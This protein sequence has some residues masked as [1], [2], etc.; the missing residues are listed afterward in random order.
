MLLP[1]LRWLLAVLL[2]CAALAA[3]A[4]AWA[5][6]DGSVPFVVSPEEVVDRMLRIAQLRPDDY[7][8]D[9]G[10][11]DGRIVIEA[12]RRGAR[13]LGVD[14]DPSLVARARESAARE[15]LAERA[16]FEVRD[17]FDTDLSRATVITLYLLPEFNLKLMPRLLALKPGTRVVS[18]DWDMGSWEPD[19]TIELRV[20][21]K[22]LGLEPR[23]KVYL[24]VIPADVRGNWVAEI[25]GYARDWQFR[26]GQTVQR[27]EVTARIDGREMLVRGTRLRG[28]E[29]RLALTGLVGGHAAHH[30]FKGTVTGDRIAGEV[31]ISDGD[32][33]RTLAWRATRTSR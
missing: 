17:L 19:E 2:A 31:V 8:V 28:T 22:T 10:S 11:G 5:W 23:S 13:G 9:L 14:L 15:G 30:L 3:R 1:W 27:M 26:I 4:Q 18:H 24:W 16:K 20:A 29:I 12:A 25:P 32:E 7:V 6:D 21:E 33:S